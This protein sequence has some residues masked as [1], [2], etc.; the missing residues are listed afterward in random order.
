MK[1][2]IRLA[3]VVGGP[4]D[5]ERDAA[6]AWVKEALEAL[7]NNDKEFPAGVKSLTVTKIIDGEKSE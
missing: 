2:E 6:N 3:W 1:Y 7:D 5:T 4:T